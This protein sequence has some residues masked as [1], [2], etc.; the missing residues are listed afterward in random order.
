[1]RVNYIYKSKFI[2]SYTKYLQFV[3]LLQSCFPRNTF[4]AKLPVLG[5]R[6]QQQP[7]HQRAGLPFLPQQPLGGSLWPLCGTVP[8]SPFRLALRSATHSFISSPL[9]F[10]QRIC[11]SVV[12]CVHLTY[13]FNYRHEAIKNSSYGIYNAHQAGD[14]DPFPSP[15]RG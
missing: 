7:Q 13:E 3:T 2:K 5:P 9:P 1:M 12:T 4:P 14:S 11:C 10:S 15:R 8:S 6:S